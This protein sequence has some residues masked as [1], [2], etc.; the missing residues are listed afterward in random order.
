[1]TEY[2]GIIYLKGCPVDEEGEPTPTPMIIPH[3]MAVFDAK[4]F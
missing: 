1:M 2:D 4:Y 3:L